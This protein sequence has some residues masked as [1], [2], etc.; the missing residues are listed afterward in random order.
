MRHHRSP[1]LR[2]LPPR[3]ALALTL[4]LTEH[5]S[6]ARAAF[7]FLGTVLLA[8]AAISVGRQFG[9]GEPI[10]W[11][12]PCIIALLG[13]GAVG[14]GVFSSIESTQDNEC[15]DPRADGTGDLGA[16]PD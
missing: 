10:E 4:G 9:A 3:S 8:V 15:N 6:S 16:D 13:L 5:M 2:R 7:Y 12:G 1:A 14:L 11:Q